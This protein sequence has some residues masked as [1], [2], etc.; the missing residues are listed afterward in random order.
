MATA[1]ES[2]DVDDDTHI[3][4]L[5]ERAAHGPV[6]LRRRNSVYRLEPTFGSEDI[7]SGYDPESARRA[8]L[9]VAG[10]WSDVD[11]EELKAYIYR[12]RDE[13]NRPAERP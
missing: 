3:G 6:F 1:R 12:G 13:G 7:W 9:D 10:A 11:P 8:L 4:P 2:I 5:L